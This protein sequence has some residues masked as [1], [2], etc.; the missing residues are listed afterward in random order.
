MGDEEWEEA[1]KEAREFYEWMGDEPDGQDLH[2]L[3]LIIYGYIRAVK[4]FGDP[5]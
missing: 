3:A 4:V 1:L 5:S 2:H